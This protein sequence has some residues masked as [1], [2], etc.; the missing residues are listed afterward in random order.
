MMTR[1]GLVAVCGAVAVVSAVAVGSGQAQ[2][3]PAT[4]DDLLVEIRGL[5]ADLAQTAGANTRM[6]LLVARLTIQEQRVNAVLREYAAINADLERVIAERSDL[7]ER[8]R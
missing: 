7:D 5:R 6:Q 4:M 3:G 8:S 1:R 2:R